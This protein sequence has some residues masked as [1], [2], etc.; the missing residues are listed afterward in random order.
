MLVI[1]HG[2]V[3]YDGPLSGITERFGRSKLVRLHFADEETLKE[4]DQF[5]EYTSSG[6]VAEL[7]VERTRVADVPATILDR[8]TVVDMSV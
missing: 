4:L 7:K 1:T 5:G 3:I 6:P 8:H 2:R